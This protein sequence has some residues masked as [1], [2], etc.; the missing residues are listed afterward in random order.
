MCYTQTYDNV[1]DISQKEGSLLSEKT[2]DRIVAYILENQN[3][4]YR[5]AYYY[6][7]QKEPALDI[8]Q[9]AIVKALENCGS[10]KNPDAVNTWMY[11]I[12]VNEALTY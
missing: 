12:V 2:Y 1:I 10:L 7:N 11:R 4:L 6:V 3:K 9:N 8:V 5:L